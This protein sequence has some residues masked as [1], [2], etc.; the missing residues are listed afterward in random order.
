MQFEEYLNHN[1]LELAMHELEYVGRKQNCSADFWR[2]M[3]HAADSMSLGNSADSYRLELGRANPG[4]EYTI[5]PLTDRPTVRVCGIAFP[6]SSEG[7]ID[8]VFLQ[9]I[10]PPAW[11]RFC[12]GEGVAYFDVVSDQT[13]AEELEQYKE[14]VTDL[15]ECGEFL[16][17]A[18]A[19]EFEQ[20]E[21]APAQI[22]IDFSN[23][24]NLGFRCRDSGTM[25]SSEVVI[26]SSEVADRKVGG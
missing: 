19:H 14:R 5:F 6:E 13:A 16:V 22:S 20:G 2:S 17:I 21:E 4:E 23:G 10:D 26:R 15:M 25:N 3:Q 9:H 7:E 8:L 1:E 12:L 11:S 18:L 24:L